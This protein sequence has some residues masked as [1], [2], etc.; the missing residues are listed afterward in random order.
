MQGMIFILEIPNDIFSRF[1]SKTQNYFSA[2]SFIKHEIIFSA[3]SFLKPKNIS[4]P[5]NLYLKP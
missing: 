1:F 5:L 3:V 4:S 2:D